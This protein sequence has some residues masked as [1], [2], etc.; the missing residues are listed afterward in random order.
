MSVFKSEESRVKA[1]EVKVERLE[2]HVKEIFKMVGKP[3][4]EP[5]EEEDDDYCAIS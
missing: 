4:S 2:K 3:V 1:L 5:D